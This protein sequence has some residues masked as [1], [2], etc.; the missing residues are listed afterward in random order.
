MTHRRHFDIFSAIKSSSPSISAGITIRTGVL[1]EQEYDFG[2]A[3]LGILKPNLA[4]P[5]PDATT[6]RAV[7]GA[8]ARVMKGAKNRVLIGEVS[9]FAPK[10]PNGIL[11]QTKD[12]EYRKTRQARVFRELGYTDLA[13][14][15]WA[16]PWSTS[17]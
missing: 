6:D 8:V 17:T 13:K 11:C 12:V 15:S 2:N 14:S 4:V 1:I 3:E 7:V 16:Y 10:L 5:K 9:T